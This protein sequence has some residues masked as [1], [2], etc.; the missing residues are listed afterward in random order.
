MLPCHTGHPPQSQSVMQDSPKRPTDRGGFSGLLRTGGVGLC[1]VAYKCLHSSR[2]LST[3][4]FHCYIPSGFYRQR[5]LQRLWLFLDSQLSLIHNRRNLE[6]SI[7]KQSTGRN[8]VISSPFQLTTILSWFAGLWS[9]NSSL[10][11]PTDLGL[12]YDNVFV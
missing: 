12:H 6:F 3:T 11:S 2:I 4:C 5:L 7:K 1:R 8:T 10:L 9:V